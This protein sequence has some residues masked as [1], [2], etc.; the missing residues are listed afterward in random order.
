MRLGEAK[1][2][3]PALVPVLGKIVKTNKP[4]EMHMI[5]AA[6]SLEKLVA[7]W[8]QGDT[9]L[10]PSEIAK[11]LALGKGFL[12]S[13]KWLNERSLEKGRNSFH[14][15]ATPHI[16]PFVVEF[17]VPQPKGAMVLQGRGFC[18]ACEQDGSQCELWCEQHQTH[19]KDCP[20]VQGFAASPLEK[21][22]AARP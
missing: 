18:G 17:K 21:G 9:F 19:T 1:H 16:H 8:D 7:I 15:V 10:S 11:T 22:H 14:I 3:L 5:S 13:Y 12:D 4:E 2:L 6:S 20:K